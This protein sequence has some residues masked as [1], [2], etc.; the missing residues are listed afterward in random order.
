MRTRLL[1]LLIVLM[2]AVLLAL[3]IPLAISLA[4]AQQQK[5]VVDRMDDTARFASLAQYINRAV[6][7]PGITA[8]Q[9]PGAKVLRPAPDE[10][11]EAL[12][13]ELSRYFRVY[14]IRAGVFDRNGAAIAAAPEAWT[15]PESGER[16]YR[17]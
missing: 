10:R 5:V 14:R 11:E 3:G 12:R 15:L 9:P 4:A 13:K 17:D 6:A 2:A 7:N 1:P 8:I 16:D